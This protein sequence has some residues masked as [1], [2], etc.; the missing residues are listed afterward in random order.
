[1][2]YALLI[3][4]TGPEVVKT[5]TNEDVTKEALG[6]ASTHTTKSGVAHGS[7]PN[8]VAALRAMRRLLDFLPASNEKGTM[9]IK[10]ITDPGD[11]KVPEI[12]RL[13]PDDPNTPYDM[14]DVIRRVVDHGE[15]FEIM[16]VRRTIQ[17]TSIIML[18]ELCPHHLGFASP[19]PFVVRTTPR[20]FAPRLP[21]W[22]AKLLV[23]S[24]RSYI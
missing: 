11:R 12:E 15:L 24:V 4:I 19:S 6:G 22:K 18:I 16:P 1:L 21:A 5:V 10:K 14:K 17:M 9:P 2:C 13:V 23:W 7:F 3:H 8:D 20:T